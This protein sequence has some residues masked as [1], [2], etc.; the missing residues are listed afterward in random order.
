MEKQRRSSPQPSEQEPPAAQQPEAIPGAGAAPEEISHEE[1]VRGERR[2]PYRR[3]RELGETSLKEEK[4]SKTAP[5]YLFGSPVDSTKEIRIAPEANIS[6]LWPRR[7]PEKELRALLRGRT[8][9]DIT[10]EQRGYVR[11]IIKEKGRY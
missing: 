5:E 6:R 3:T 2:Q 8:I 1:E 9:D 11:A 4:M 7:T 10:E